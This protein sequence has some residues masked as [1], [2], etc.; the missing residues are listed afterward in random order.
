MPD[1]RLKEEVILVIGVV[2]SDGG[3]SVLTPHGL[4]RIPG[5]NP[6][7][8]EAYDAVMKSYTKLQEIAQQAG[9][10]VGR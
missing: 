6:M 8:R 7:A 5:N 1:I 4:K 9:E 3:Y 2:G 10:Q